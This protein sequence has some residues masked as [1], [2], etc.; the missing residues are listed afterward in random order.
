MVLFWTTLPPF[1]LLLPL[2]QGTNATPTGNKIPINL[3]IAEEPKRYIKNVL[4]EEFAGGIYYTMKGGYISRY[5]FGDVFDGPELIIPGDPNSITRSVLVVPREDGTKYVKVLTKY[6]GASRRP[7]VK[8]LEFLRYPTDLYY[9]KIQRAPLEFDILDLNHN[10]MINAKLLGDW[11]KHDE[12]VANGRATMDMPEN[13]ETLPMKFTIQ[14]NMRDNFTIGLVKY[15]G[16]VI[17][18]RTDG[19]LNREVTWEGGLYRPRIIILSRYADNTEIRGDEPGT[20]TDIKTPVVI[21]APKAIVDYEKLYK[22]MMEVG[23]GTTKTQTKERETLYDEKVA[24][25]DPVSRRELLFELLKDVESR[26]AFYRADASEMEMVGSSGYRIMV[27][28]T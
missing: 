17:E 3:D 7:I 5:V 14:G 22:K 25:S 9:T 24:L 8:V 20:S 21:I 11:K 26:I 28:S 18:S 13:L 4:S 12:D 2:L 6:V 23:P 16:Y 27:L 10:H 15:N 19:L 1:I